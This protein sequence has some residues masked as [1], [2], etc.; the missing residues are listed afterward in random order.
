MGTNYCGC[1]QK[2]NNEEDINFGPSPE[3]DINQNSK[4]EE[5][6]NMTHNNENLDKNINTSEKW[7]EFKKNFEIK[8]PELGEYISKEPFYEKIPKKAFSFMNK[9]EFTCPDDIIINKEIYLMNPIKLKNGNIYEGNWNKNYKMEGKG[10]YYKE[11]EKIFIEGIWAEGVLIYGRIYYP[12]ENICEGYIKN[13]KWNGKGKLIYNTGDIYEGDFINGEMEGKGKLTFIDNTIYEGN[14]SKGKYNGYGTMKWIVDTISITYEGEFSEACLNNNGKLI[15]NDGEK[16]E[17]N[18][19]DNFFNGKGKY[20]FEDGSTYEGDFDSGKRNGK[21]IYDK[22]DEFNYDGSWADDYAHGTGTFTKGNIII[23]G[24][25]A[26]GENV[27]ISSIEG[28]QINDFNNDI[29]NF[30]IPNINLIPDRLPHLGKIRNNK[31]F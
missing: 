12:N 21:G 29:L 22:K 3:I 16:Y 25:W 18:F 7:Y 5:S 17:G 2:N 27:D 9:N 24:T 30:K 10:K 6:A 23:K 13:S 28:A 14:F 31:K 20:T 11:N 19:K 15:N 8:L 1:C 26:N 4:K